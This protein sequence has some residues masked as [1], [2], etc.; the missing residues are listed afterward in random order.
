MEAIQT[1]EPFAVDWR[2]Q[3][4]AYLDDDFG[5]DGTRHSHGIHHR[6]S[7]DQSAK[8][9]KYCHQRFNVTTDLNPLPQLADVS[10]GLKY[11]HDWPSVHADLK[12]VSWIHLGPSM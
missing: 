12:G 4:S 1:P 5:L 3:N 7:R 2:D 11:L 8:T 9:G 10:R 6:M